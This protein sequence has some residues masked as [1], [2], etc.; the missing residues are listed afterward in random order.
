MPPLAQT[1]ANQLLTDAARQ[2]ELHPNTTAPTNWEHR[3]NF[4]RPLPTSGH[5]TTA[6]LEPG[7]TQWRVYGCGLSQERDAVVFADALGR[8]LPA[9]KRWRIGVVGAPAELDRWVV[10]PRANTLDSEL[11]IV[12]EAAYNARRDR[13]DPV[14]IAAL[15]EQRQLQRSAAV[16]DRREARR[17]ARLAELDARRQQRQQRVAEARAAARAEQAGMRNR[18]QA[19]RAVARLGQ[20]AG[21][22]EAVVGA[23]MEAVA[24]IGRTNAT[25]AAA[26]AI[27]LASAWAFLQTKVPQL[28]AA[29]EAAAD[30]NNECVVCMGAP[31]TM[32]FTA[33]GHAVTCAACTARCCSYGDQHRCPICRSHGSVLRL[34]FA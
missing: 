33:C 34:H 16:A 24:N 3:G 18:Q 9:T 8:L 21:A 2:A 20:E 26:P 7:E 4:G 13:T 19:V 30:T 12:E 22:T 29:Q 14:R 1:L 5:W 11:A 25:A 31:A 6:G 32:A 28:I 15:R 10:G 27:D 23:A 17:L